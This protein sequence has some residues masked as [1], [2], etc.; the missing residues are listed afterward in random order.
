MKDQ[1]CYIVLNL[2]GEKINFKYNRS[3]S[4]LK[5]QVGK[6]WVKVPPSLT[7]ACGMNMSKANIIQTIKI[8]EHNLMN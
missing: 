1:L 8:K 4:D 6:R 3:F 2:A 5:M 7:L